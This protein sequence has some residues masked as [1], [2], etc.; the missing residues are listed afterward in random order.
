MLKELAEQLVKEVKAKVPK[1]DL[2]AEDIVLITTT[3]LYTMA[4]FS[5]K[6]AAHN[7]AHFLRSAGDLVIGGWNNAF[8]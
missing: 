1:V 3:T 8:E 5:A 4:G 2:S 7:R 6:E